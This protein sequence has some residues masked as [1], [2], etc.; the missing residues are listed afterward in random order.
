[1]TSTFFGLN[2]ALQGLMAQRM[3]LDVSAH[4]VANANTDGYSRQEALMQA[5]PPF[6]VPTAN[7][8]VEAGQLG[9]GVQ[10]SQ[11]RR[12]RDDFLDYQIRGQLS[13]L[14]G[15]QTLQ[16]TLSQIEALVNEPS[17]TGLAVA[18]SNMWA[19]WQDLSAN[20][21]SYAARAVVVQSSS[22]LADALR[23]GSAQLS[24]LRDQVGQAITMKVSDMN[25]WLQQ[26]ASLNDQIVKVQAA[27]DQ[28]NDLRDQRDLLLDRLAQAARITY[29][30]QADGSV[31]VWLGSD[32]G[33]TDALLVEGSRSYPL[34]DSSGALTSTQESLVEDGELKALLDCRDGALDP[35][36]AGSLAYRWNALAATLIQEVNSR[37]TPD[38]SIPFFTGSGASDIAVNPDLVADPSQVQAGTGGPGDGSTALGIARLATT[39]VSIDGQMTTLGEWYNALVTRLGTDIEQ[40]KAMT[41]NQQSL[42][43]HLKTNREALSG[44]S[45]DEEAANMVRYERAYQASARVMTAMD[46]M[47]DRIINGMGVVGR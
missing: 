16:D 31:K 12:L 37:H 5:T 21:D 10:V 1:M 38:G 24:Q 26:I 18:L 15:W 13:A 27:G 33:N 45:L 36:A 47:L 3:A 9:T 32:S 2:I 19:A 14:G 20:P 25:T 17:D 6:T 40:A 41:A 8:L 46:E 44:V 7:R 42:V 11:V 35:A 43:N 28:P 39:P 30:E 29:Q 22:V 23:T 34:G 4:N